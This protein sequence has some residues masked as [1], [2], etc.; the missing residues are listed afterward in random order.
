MLFVLKGKTNNSAYIAL[1]FKTSCSLYF[2]PL[3]EQLERLKHQDVS[4]NDILTTFLLQHIKKLGIDVNVLTPEELQKILDE[5]GREN[6]DEALEKPDYNKILNSIEIAFAKEFDKLSDEQKKLC[7]RNSNP[8]YLKNKIQRIRELLSSGIDTVEKYEKLHGLLNDVHAALNT[9]WSFSK[10]EKSAIEAQKVVEILADRIADRVGSAKIAELHKAYVESVKERARAQ[11]GNINNV[12]GHGVDDKTQVYVYGEYDYLMTTVNRR[13]VGK[14]DSVDHQ[15]ES[16]Y[17]I[18]I[19][20]NEHEVIASNLFERFQD[21]T[22][23]GVIVRSAN[24]W[25]FCDYF[26]EDKKVKVR[27]IFDIEADSDFIKAFE[28]DVRDKTFRSAE[29]FNRWFESFRNRYRQQN[30]GRANAST[31]LESNDNAGMA[32]SELQEGDNANTGTGTEQSGRDISYSTVKTQYDGSTQPRIIFVEEQNKPDLMTTTPEEGQEMHLPDDQEA[33]LRAMLD[34]ATGKKQPTASPAQSTQPA[35]QPQSV[36][37]QQAAQPSQPAQQPA[38]PAQPKRG[39]VFGFKYNGKIYLNKEKINPNTIIHELTHLWCDVVQGGNPKLWNNIKEMLRNETLAIELARHLRLNVN[40]KELSSDKMMGEV[41][42]RLVGQKGRE[43]AEAIL[44]ELNGEPKSL[45]EKLLASIRSLWKWVGVNIFQLEKVDNIDELVDRVLYDII[46]GNIVTKQ[47]GIFGNENNN[48]PPSA[49]GN[50][51]VEPDGS[52]SQTK[53]EEEAVEP[54]PE[55]EREELERKTKEEEELRK[56]REKEINEVAPSLQWTSGA[57]EIPLWSE[58]RPTDENGTDHSKPYDFDSDPITEKRYGKGAWNVVYDALRGNGHKHHTGDYNGGTCVDDDE[59]VMSN[60]SAFDYLN[61]GKLESDDKLQFMVDKET[62]IAIVNK[63]GSVSITYPVFLVKKLENGKYQKV[64]ILRI[65]SMLE[66][67]AEDN[68]ANMS[69]LQAVIDF[70]DKLI[71]QA[72]KS[73]QRYTFSEQST[74]VSS[75]NEGSPRWIDGKHLHPDVKGFENEHRSLDVA[76]YRFLDQHEGEGYV[77]RM[78]RGVDEKGNP[79]QH[80]VL[81]K[82][83]IPVVDPNVTSISFQNKHYSEAINSERVQSSISQFL[84]AAQGAA[85]ALSKLG[86]KIKDRNER[87]KAIKGILDAALAGFISSGIIYNIGVSPQGNV[88]LAF[89]HRKAGADSKSISKDDIDDNDKVEIQIISH[90]KLNPKL[91]EEYEMVLSKWDL[92]CAVDGKGKSWTEIEINLDDLT[93]ENREVLSGLTINASSLIPCGAYFTYNGIDSKSGQF[94]TFV[95]GKKV[96]TPVPLPTPTEVGQRRTMK[97]RASNGNIIAVEYTAKPDGSVVMDDVDDD[98]N[99]GQMA[100]QLNAHREQIMLASGNMQQIAGTS[101]SYAKEGNI[102]VLK[103]LKHTFYFL[104]RKE[105]SDIYDVYVHDG[106]AFEYTELLESIRPKAKEWIDKPEDMVRFTIES[107][108]AINELEGVDEALDE[109]THQTMSAMREEFGTFNSQQP[110]Q[111]EQQPQPAETQR[112]GMTREQWKSSR[113]EVYHTVR[114]AEGL[115]HVYESTLSSTRDERSREFYRKRNEKDY[116]MWKQVVADYNSIRWEGEDPSHFEL[117]TLSSDDAIEGYTLIVR[118]I[119]PADSP[120]QS[121]PEQ[122]Q[123]QQPAQP[124]QPAQPEAKQDEP[125]P[126][127]D[128]GGKK[129]NKKSINMMAEE[130]EGYDTAHEAEMQEIKA[131]AIAD[132]TFMKAPNGKSTKLKERQWLQVRTKAFKDWFGDWTKITFD[133]NGKVL[134]IPDDVSKIV[135]ENGEPLV[136]YHGTLSEFTVFDFNRLGETTGEGYFIDNI[137]GEKIP[138]DSSYAFFFTDNYQAAKTYKYASIWNQNQFRKQ[139]YSN[140]AGI[141]SNTRIGVVNFKGKQHKDQQEFI[142]NVLSP[143]MGFDVRAEINRILHKT[144]TLSDAQREAYSKKFRA[145]AAKLSSLAPMQSLSN[146]SNGLESDKKDLNFILEHKDDLINGTHISRLDSRVLHF[147]SGWGNR[148][149]GEVFLTIRNGENQY[150]VTGLPNTNGAVRIAAQNFDAIIAEIKKAIVQNG[151]TLAQLEREGHYDTQGSVM[152]LFLNIR[153]PIEHDYEGSA[154]TGEYKNERIPTSRIAAQQTQKAIQEGKDGVVYKNVTDPLNM[155]SYGIFKGNQVKSATD[156]NG[157]FSGENDNIDFMAEETPEQ[158][159]ER[160]NT[161]FVNYY[162][163]EMSERT[164][165]AFFKGIDHAASQ[166]FSRWQRMSEGLYALNQMKAGEVKL[167]EAF[168]AVFE[169]LL[170]EKEKEQIHKEYEATFGKIDVEKTRNLTHTTKIIYK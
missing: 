130:E 54:N 86:E 65:P 125:Q 63:N 142:D 30:N 99:Y 156:N 8:R 76:V 117:V 102:M 11:G 115:I 128:K 40:Y 136:V 6:V 56:Q 15:I 168:H 82:D 74:T 94:G 161:E 107:A 33:R 152:E 24:N 5:I 89:G 3:A 61:L 16:G 159:R 55:K 27:A 49:G 118:R 64:S 13:T 137:T 57:P 62:R 50:T 121:Q 165:H 53:D 21:K 9:L 127:Q 17:Y 45:F 22:K 59:E 139:I 162:Y 37:P 2:F 43:R 154:F 77:I 100:E 134:N 20:P 29:G 88:T 92:F 85:E 69:D 140:L 35:Q 19:E 52:V 28:K 1:S 151:E 98:V 48:T 26:G 67:N 95:K 106:E 119:K 169:V 103:G 51:V 78:V 160:K 166:G 84:F 110:T 91:R 75:V 164:K 157:D 113:D 105:G 131:K 90:F 46:M 149:D 32:V 10:G 144:S 167:A 132:G 79:F 87:F 47:E 72:M 81:T 36:Q 146:L 70:R 93:P 73:E 97:V 104:P 7:A 120:V 122:Q 170:T 123:P 148:E 39:V 145:M 23:Y 150:T 124:A 133:K 60:E 111:P 4:P 41:I 116:K 109:N 31:R 143:F 129:K 138:F 12:V 80:V 38:Q 112:T 147:M 163:T 153:N 155:T 42:A 101:V 108:Q 114:C 141:F 135:D 158:E 68:S 34:A 96:E 66:I 18:P 83:E 71:A 14:S 44:K 25:Y 126:Q 58:E